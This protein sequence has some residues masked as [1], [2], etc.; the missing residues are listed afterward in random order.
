MGKKVTFE[1][2][3]IG[4]ILYVYSVQ[5]YEAQESTELGNNVV[6]R[7]HPVSGELE[8]LEI[9]WFKRRI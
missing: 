1:Y 2:D 5:P 6:A 3:K 8:C 9:L 4:D 7:Y